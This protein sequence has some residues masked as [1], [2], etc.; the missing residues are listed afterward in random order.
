VLTKEQV[1]ELI[2]KLDDPVVNIPLKETGGVKEVSIKEEKNH[3]SVKIGI[4]KLGG[5]EQLDLQTKIV[6]V[7]KENG[8][9]TLIN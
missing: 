4:A 3:V 5:Q 2:E 9:N 1:I 6:E 7:L 8:A